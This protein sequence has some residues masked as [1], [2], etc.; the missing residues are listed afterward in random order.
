MV[1]QYNKVNCFFLISGYLFLGNASMHLDIF[2]GTS[3]RPSAP[4]ENH[5]FRYTQIH[6]K[7]CL[8]YYS[9]K[10]V[11][12]K[13]KLFLLITNQFCSS[14][15]HYQKPSPVWFEFSFALLKVYRTQSALL[16]THSR[17]GKSDKFVLL[18]K[19]Y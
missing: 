2:R 4:F 9:N 17:K 3:V 11:R 12:L 15:Q 10:N 1:L 13:L 8:D 14:S 7:G 16:F 6:T 18:L 5:W 19:G